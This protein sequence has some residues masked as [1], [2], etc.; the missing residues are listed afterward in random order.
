MRSKNALIVAPEYLNM[1]KDIS[2]ALADMSYDVYF[3]PDIHLRCDPYNKHITWLKMPSALFIRKLNK[4]WNR[5]FSSD[6]A[7]I[8]FDFVL[9]ID[10][11]SVSPEFFSILKKRNTKVRIV[12]YLFD[13]IDGF[14][15]VQRNF[16][17][18]DDVYSFDL[19]DSVKY[20]INLLPIYWLPC[21][22]DDGPKYRLFGFGAY[23]DR[24]YKMFK[25]I[26]QLLRDTSGQDLIQLW[27][28]KV[29]NKVIY[30]IECK[31]KSFL[32]LKYV[33]YNDLKTDLFTSQTIP[34]TEFRKIISRSEVILD[35]CNPSQS[36]LTARFM[37]AL[38]LR[39]KIITSNSRVCEYPFYST[40]LI[41]L[42]D[43]SITKERLLE[44]IDRDI[45]TFDERINLVDNYVVDKW[46]KLI[47]K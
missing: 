8:V 44:F 7:N 21:Q 45:N 13:K 37:W 24:R 12:N 16:S 6:F 5:L 10:G 43:S 2:T 41:L 33:P 11:L 31:V 32:G 20:K 38:G 26:K 39:K 22:P 28:K 14:Y 29:N 17:C 30:D 46:L 15:E 27:H 40:D 19:D 1:Y 47:L 34:T 23:E 25:N 18:Y 9:V 36:G 4:Y 42:Y 3:A 35:S